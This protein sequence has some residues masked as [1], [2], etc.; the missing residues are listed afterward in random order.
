[1]FSIAGVI[2]SSTGKRAT[3]ILEW[4]HVR[5]EQEARYEEDAWEQP[6]AAF[7]SLKEHVTILQVATDVLDML[8]GKVNRADQNRIAAALQ[9]L[10]WERKGKVHGVT[11][12]ALFCWWIGSQATIP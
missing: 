12:A 5:R 11:L 1:M 4:Q 9:R 3:T 2:Q 6:I 10:G 7:L 8:T